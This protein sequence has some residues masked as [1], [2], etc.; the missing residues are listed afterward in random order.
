M[1]KRESEKG[2]EDKEESVHIVNILYE[3]QNFFKLFPRDAIHE[4]D[5]N[6]TICIITKRL[7]S[8]LV[9]LSS[10]FF[11]SSADD[12]HRVLSFDKI[13]Y[14]EPCIYSRSVLRTY[15]ILYL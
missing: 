1:C 5:T 15:F 6:C 8:S 9:L 11:Y 7:S 12:F 10:L 13:F 2:R 14:H 4:V 3:E